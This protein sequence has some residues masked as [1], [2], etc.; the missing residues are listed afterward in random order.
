MAVKDQCRTSTRTLK[1]IIR[2]V[3]PQDIISLIINFL[4]QCL[5]SVSKRFW[6]EVQLHRVRVYSPVHVRDAGWMA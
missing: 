6:F 3:I 5:S 4:P 2:P 1:R